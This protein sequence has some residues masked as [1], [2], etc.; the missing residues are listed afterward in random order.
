[1]NRR[2]L[3]CLAAAAVMVTAAPA[4]AQQSPLKLRVNYS[5]VPPHLV[6]VFFLK[7]DL[8]KHEGKSYTRTCSGAIKRPLAAFVPKPQKPAQ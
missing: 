3:V 2:H 4:M 8:I 7:K 1:M 6:P 5:V